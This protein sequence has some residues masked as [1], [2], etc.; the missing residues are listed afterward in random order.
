M[1]N[2]AG[3]LPLILLTGATGYVGGRLLKA[4][5]GKGYSV[6]C[7]ARHPE[8]LRSKVPPSVEV[9]EGDITKPETLASAL[10]GV[11]TVY[12]LVHSMNENL[13]YEE[14][15]RR[16][17]EELGR[18]AKAAGVKK[19]IYLGGLGNK[20][21]LSPHLRSRQEVG[22]LLRES[23]VPTVEFQA[24]IIIGSGSFSFEMI[25]ALVERLPVMV[26]PRWVGTLCQPIAINDVIAYL[27]EAMEKD[28]FQSQVFPIGGYKSVSYGDLMGEYARQRGLRRYLIPVPFLTP[29]LSSLWLGLVTPV[30]ARVG[31]QLIEGLRYETTV[32]DPSALAFFAVRPMGVGEAIA[33]ALKNENEDI[34]LTRWSDAFSSV[35]AR[36]TTARFG[37]RIVDSRTITVKAPLAQ[38]FAPIESIGGKN[39]W[40]YADFLWKLRGFMDLLVG[41]AGVRRGRKDPNHLRVGDNLD[42][43]RVEAIDPPRLLRL[44]AEMVLPGRAWLQFELSEKDG[45]T[46]I[47][48]TALFDPSGLAGLLYWYLLYPVHALLFEGMLRRIGERGMSGKA[49]Q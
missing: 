41:G 14:R 12:Y 29:H 21:P 31:R 34:A 32:T 45:E 46:R 23:G 1:K 15:D 2:P 7:L 11:H 42:F 20:G 18:E 13:D 35:P 40:Y 28:F 44:R 27:V 4:L 24:S 33:L 37:N 36:V 17:A 49:A 10:K 8:S 5:V 9:V 22:R 6:R 30:Y 39:G 43:W 48:Q 25:R 3:N 19:I 38:A 16:A 47:T 26:T